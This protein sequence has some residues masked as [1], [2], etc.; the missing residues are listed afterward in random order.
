MP[1]GMLG[2]TRPLG[3]ERFACVGLVPH[4]IVTMRGHSLGDLASIRPG[5]ARS[6][7]SSLRFI[8]FHFNSFYSIVFILV[9]FVL[10]QEQRD[11][12]RL[13]REMASLEASE[14]LPEH[15]PHLLYTRLGSLMRFCD[16]PECLAPFFQHFPA[17][18]CVLFCAAHAPTGCP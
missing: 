4:M 17:E 5:S 6:S 15:M 3:P 2:P 18:K 8:S 14:P 9:C 10:A 16:Y 13:W 12:S 11:E 7:L 1:E